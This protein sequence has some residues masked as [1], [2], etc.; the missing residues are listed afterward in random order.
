MER[1]EPYGLNGNVMANVIVFDPNS[2]PVPNRIREYLK[3]VNTTHYKDRADVLINP[4]L[5]EGIALGLL[6]VLNGEVVELTQSDLDAIAYQHS[7]D[8]AILEAKRIREAKDF[9]KG[10]LDGDEGYEVFLNALVTVIVQQFNSL[11]SQHGLG[12][13]TKDQVKAAIVSEIGS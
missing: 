10:V 8:T 4:V 2:V 12:N 3:S 1:T 5:P 13:I 9:A 6:K 7:L 11:R